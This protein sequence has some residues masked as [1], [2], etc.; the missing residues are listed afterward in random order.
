[1]VRKISRRSRVARATSADGLADATCG[2]SRVG[3]Y[4]TYPRARRSEGKDARWARIRD[5]HRPTNQLRGLC[6]EQ[7]GTAP[8]DTRRVGDSGRYKD[9]DELGKGFEGRMIRYLK[10]LQ[11][12][13]IKCGEK[14]TTGFVPHSCGNDAIIFECSGG[15]LGEND[16]ALPEEKHWHYFCEVC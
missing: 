11:Y 16:C 4:A 3:L 12:A 2:L 8:Q 6:K 9:W 13:K 7:Y 15:E 14:T 10:P 5:K 1:M